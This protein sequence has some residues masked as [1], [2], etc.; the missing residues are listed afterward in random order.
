MPVS[1]R[2]SKGDAKIKGPHWDIVEKGGKVVGHSAT[3]KKANITASIRNRN[4]K[5]K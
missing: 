3:Q 2:K 1:V 4:S 5:R